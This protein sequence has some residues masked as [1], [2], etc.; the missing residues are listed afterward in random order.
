[1][2]NNPVNWFEIPVSD[3]KRA[4]AFYETLLGIKLPVNKFSHL[5]MAWFPY[6]E[7]GAGAS[8]SLVYDPEHYSPN[9]KGTLVYFTSPSGDLEN[10]LAKV[11]NAGGKILVPKKQISAEYGFMAMIIDSEGNRVALHS[12]K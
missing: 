6:S 1:M 3:M 5:E 8:G 2:K 10:E 12:D 11:E 7:K 4:V 9:D